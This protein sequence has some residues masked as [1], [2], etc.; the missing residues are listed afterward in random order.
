MPIAKIGTDTSGSGNALSLSYSHTLVAGDNRMVVVCIFYENGD[1][2]DVT[3]VSY[4]GQA[5]T[6]AVEALTGTTGFRFLTEIWYILEADLP[7]NGSN[8]VAI[9]DAGTLSSFEVS[10][11]C[12]EYTG[13]AQTGTVDDTDGFAETSSADAIIE[14]SVTL[15]DNAWVVSSFGC[16]NTGSWT[17]HNNSQVE[18]Y[19]FADASSAHGVAELRGANGE[20]TLTSTF[21]A[22]ANRMAR[23][24]FSFNEHV[25]VTQTHQMM[26]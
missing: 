1:A 17:A 10:S 25:G 11:F 6:K 23:A 8:T 3:S 26:L 15:T 9:T 19:D 5:M 21:S 13:V 4:G 2:I 16:G 18:V 24:A 14:N 7:A 12:A 20:T 22:S